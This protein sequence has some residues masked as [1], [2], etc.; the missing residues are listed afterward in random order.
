VAVGVETAHVHTVRT[1][2]HSNY[3]K[4]SMTRCTFPSLAA[5]R[6]SMGCQGRSHQHSLQPQC[7]TALSGRVVAAYAGGDLKQRSTAVAHLNVQLGTYCRFADRSPAS[8]AR[9]T[10]PTQPAGRMCKAQGPAHLHTGLQQS[11]YKG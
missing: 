9:H 1:S 8:R 7:V 5:E 2:E 11:S 3:P 10:C 6:T 4:A